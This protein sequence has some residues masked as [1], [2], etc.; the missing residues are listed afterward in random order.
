M[1]VG[2]G[3]ES[4][5]ADAQLV[6]GSTITG[7]VTDAL[8]HI[9]IEGIPV[10]AVAE[11]GL[12][13]SAGRCESSGSGGT[14]LI[15]GLSP[16]DY[17]VEFQSGYLNYLEQHYDDSVWPEP[18]TLV[19][20]SA[21]GETITGVDAAMR[22]GAEIEGRVTDEA[23]E[24]AIRGLPAGEYRI[25]FATSGSRSLGTCYDSSW[26]STSAGGPATPVQA[27][28]GETAGG[29]DAGLNRACELPHPEPSATPGPASG[30]PVAAALTKT[31]GKRRS[32]RPLAPSRD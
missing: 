27:T 31:L 24:Y 13:G 10:C 12:E 15:N 28:L 2:S 23:G 20:I 1:T 3:S 17:E 25:S 18:L 7:A 16:G 19:P 22:V 8:S 32:R 9:G 5:T 29:I 30:A 11:H 6:P 26:Y 21:A 14:Y 4:A